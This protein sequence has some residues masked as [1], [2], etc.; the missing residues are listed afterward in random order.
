MTAETGGRPPE[1]DW[2]GTPY[3][4]FERHGPLARCVVD[5][6]EARNAMTPAMYFGVRYASN[7]VDADPDLAGLLIAGTGDVFIPG[8]DM[9]GANSPDDWGLPHVLGMEI[10]PFDALR[11]AQKPVVCAVNGIC[12]GGG[13]MIA[14]LSDMAVAS[15]RATFRTP[16]LFRGIADT[17]YGHILARHVGP[18]R[19]RDLLF[20]GRT[21]DADEAVSWGLITRVVPHDELL[22]AATEVLVACC[23]T[24]PGARTDI[25]REL[26][27]YYGLYDR[28][29]MKASLGG[30]EAMEGWRAFKERRPPS[31]IHPDLRPK[32]RI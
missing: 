30:E 17:H 2:L 9:G 11:Q 26:D 15:E 24:A 14:M 16:E 1:G 28:I 20:T 13:L 19:A 32:G 3:L 6:P 25:K 10:T 21:L 22:D 12:Q 31:W 4:R 29:G 8:G 23:R 7:H 18:A 5:R 27:A